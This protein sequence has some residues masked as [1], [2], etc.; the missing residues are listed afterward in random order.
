MR[1]CT[2]QTA[3]SPSPAPGGSQPAQSQ[4]AATATRQCYA[5][6]QTPDPQSPPCRQGWDPTRQNNGGATA[7]GV[8]ASTIYVAYPCLDGFF[9]RCPDTANLEKFF[10]TGKAPYPVERTLLTTGILDAVMRSH[11]DG[12]VC[13][14]SG[15]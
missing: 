15:R 11:H 13:Q 12:G 2:G 4:G 7:P 6:T 3:P 10:E 8:N 5:L 9:E 1:P 14:G